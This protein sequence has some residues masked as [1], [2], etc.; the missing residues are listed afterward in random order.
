VIE[1]ATF[2]ARAAEATEQRMRDACSVVIPGVPGPIDPDTGWQPPPVATV[3]YTGPCRFRMLGR[4]G[5]KDQQSVVVDLVTISAPILSVP[6][7]APQ[8][9]VGAVC[10]IT[11]VDSDDP[12]GH[13]RL[14]LRM[15]VIGRVLGTDVTAQRVTVEV[16]TS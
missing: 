4:V 11:A 16:V 10:T 1:D 14:G 3:V 15:R 13:L 7:W 12:A 5:A 9:P 2:R 6:L 8:V